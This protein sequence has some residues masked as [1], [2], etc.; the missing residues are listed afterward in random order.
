MQRVLDVDQIDVSLIKTM[1]PQLLIVASGH[2]PTTG[3]SKPA[4]SPWFYIRVPDDGVQDFDFVAEEPHGH[5]GD[6]VLPITAET[7]ISRD[8]Q[9]YW[10][11]GHP[12]RGVRIHARSN[13]KE[14]LFDQ[15]TVKSAIA[16]NASQAASGIGADAV[17]KVLRVYHT[18]DMLTRDWR[19][20]RMNIELS[21]QTQRIVSVWF[22]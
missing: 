5:A 7:T 4:L 8:P 10:G 14:H 6:V 13:T 2:V 18:G 22:G 1:P 17:G 16:I 11:P 19:D 12:L 9:N 15:E 21:P 20:D 3:W